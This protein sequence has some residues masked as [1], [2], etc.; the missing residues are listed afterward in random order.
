MPRANR[1]HRRDRRE[2]SRS[3]GS[4]IIGQNLITQT[5]N[6]PGGNI[7][8]MQ[9]LAL[10]ML[11]GQDPDTIVP[12]TIPSSVDGNGRAML[13]DG[14]I[15]YNATTVEVDAAGLVTATFVRVPA[16]FD[17]FFLAPN[18]PG[19]LPANFSGNPGMQHLLT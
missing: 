14:A 5:P 2:V 19:L 10:L 8:T 16:A 9:I 12:T 18:I 7:V 13:Y 15:T 3:K 6:R 1:P 4:F 17:L 11:P